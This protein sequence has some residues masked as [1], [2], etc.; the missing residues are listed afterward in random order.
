MGASR[1]ST[2]PFNLNHKGQYFLDLAKSAKA[3]EG[4]CRTTTSSPNADWYW[5][6]KKVPVTYKDFVYTWQNIDD[7]IKTNDVASTAGYDQIRRHRHAQG[8]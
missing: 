3:N 5:G 7:P 4:A 8:S 2:A 1:H 6:G